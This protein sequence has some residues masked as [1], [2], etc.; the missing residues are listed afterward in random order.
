MRF[1]LGALGLAIGVSAAAA[2]D[3]TLVCTNAG[4]SYNVGDFA[5]IAACHGERRFAKCDLV[6]TAAIW[7]YLSDSCPSAMINPPWPTDWSEVPAKVAMS[8]IPIEVNSSAIAAMIAPKIVR[9]LGS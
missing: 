7:T 8:P 2:Q 3:A 5:C 4:N 9:R 6:G 1:L